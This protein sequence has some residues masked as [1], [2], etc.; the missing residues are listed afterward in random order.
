MQEKNK[1]M[2]YLK[3]AT[4]IVII[5]FILFGLWVGYKVAAFYLPF[6]IA[7]LIATLIEPIIH[8]FMKKT[9]MKRKMASSISLILVLII[10]GSLLTLL[11]SSLIAEA[12]T[13]LANLNGTFTQVYNWSMQFLEDL[14][15]G[16]IEIPP[17]VISTI[18]NSMGSI[19]NGAKD[20]VYNILTGLVNTISSIPTMITYIFITF[21]AIVFVCFD[22]DY[23]REMVKKHVPTVWIEKAKEVTHQTCSIAWKYVKAEAKL[24]GICFC[25]VLAG[26]FVFDIV[27]LKVEY[28]IL[29]ALFIGFVDLLPLFGA[30]A[31]MVP[32]SIWL[33][34]IGNTPLAIAVLGLWL[35]WA[36][37][38]N[39]IEPKFV[40]KQM[41]MHPIFTLFGMYTGFRLLGVVGLMIGPIVLLIL[42]SVFRN[43]V[44]KGIFKSFFEL[45]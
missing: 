22:R 16:K 43:L 5:L 29:M 23:V 6:L 21:L 36:V 35:V 18:Q 38:K 9:K 28:T 8:F 31:V 33:F 25:L 15:T 34:L 14:Q 12:K 7:I 41:G 20:I 39:L 11:I 37:I 4:K 44:E 17:E 3:I 27:G 32:W 10:I 1:E 42:K 2:Y 26:L 19:L 13:L 24:S 45:E 40:S 30:G